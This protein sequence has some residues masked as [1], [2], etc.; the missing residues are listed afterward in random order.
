MAAKKEKVFDIADYQV[1]MSA[2]EMELTIPDGTKIPLTIK[3]IGWKRKNRILAQSTVPMGDG[4][5]IDID[6]YI[7]T[8]LK[9]MIVKAPWGTTSDT[10]LASIND[11]LGDALATIVPRPSE[12]GTSGVELVKK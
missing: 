3:P 7:S 12:D 1:D 4:A 2:Q 6:V 11:E 5:A 9:E 10:F 8:C